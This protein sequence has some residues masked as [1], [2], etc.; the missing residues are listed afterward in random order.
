M[1][2]EILPAHRSLSLGFI[3]SAAVATIV[4]LVAIAEAKYPYRIAKDTRCPLGIL[5]SK[6][7]GQPFN[8]YLAAFFSF[9]AYRAYRS[10]TPCAATAVAGA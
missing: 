3:A 6:S 1:L 4:A 10:S 5:S 8:G 2:A 9:L 7:V